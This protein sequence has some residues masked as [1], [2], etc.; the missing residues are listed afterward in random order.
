MADN[1]PLFKTISRYLD[2]RMMAAIAAAYDQGR[3]LLIGTTDIDAQVP[4]IW[5]IGAIAKSGHPRALEVIR[6]ILLASAAIP[7]AFPPSMIDVTVDEPASPAEEPPEV[8]LVRLSGAVSWV[9]DATAGT[10]ADASGP[11]SGA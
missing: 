10:T 1:A 8:E 7:G 3:L 5:N 11:R 4:V 6:K 2:E 9:F